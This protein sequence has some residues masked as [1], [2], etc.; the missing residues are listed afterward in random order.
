MSHPCN[1]P[2]RP[3]MPRAPELRSRTRRQDTKHAHDPLALWSF[4]LV[5]GIPAGRRGAARDAVC[6]VHRG[7]E[8][9]KCDCLA[10]LARLASSVRLQ[11]GNLSRAS[12]V[13]WITAPSGV[14]FAS[15][16]G[17]M[18]FLLSR[19]SA[20]AD[21]DRYQRQLDSILAVARRRELETPAADRRPLPD[22]CPSTGEGFAWQAN[23]AVTTAPP[24]RTTNRRLSYVS[25]RILFL[26]IASL[27]TASTWE[28]GAPTRP[29]AQP[30]PD[31][32]ERHD[33]TVRSF[34]R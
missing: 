34:S 32:G 29:G 27:C 4:L 14:R 22:D 5:T 6:T 33:Q 10:C 28:P 30:Y 12:H 3:I 1:A 20:H 19:T 21:A 8:F 25:R 7:I 13:I 16:G 17:A 31:A 26:V 24:R 9:R 23:G 2:M 15:T 11:R 18:H